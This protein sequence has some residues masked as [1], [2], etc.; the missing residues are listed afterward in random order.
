MALNFNRRGV[1]KGGAA[2]SADSITG[3]P[4]MASDHKQGQPLTEREPSRRSLN[5]LTNLET[6]Q[7]LCNSK[8][9][10]YTHSGTDSIPASGWIEARFEGE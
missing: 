1:L 5:S 3:L 2:L 8:V 7:S 10:V 9:G 6:L 4:G